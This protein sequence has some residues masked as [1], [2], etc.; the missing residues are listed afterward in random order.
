MITIKHFN[1][2]KLFMKK[3]N[4]HNNMVIVAPGSTGYMINQVEYH[5][6]PDKVEVLYGT[7]ILSKAFRTA[8]NFGVQDVFVVNAQATSDYISIIDT[9]RQYDFS[10]IIPIGINLSDTFYN[11][12]IKRQMYFAELYI[13]QVSRFN[14]S[15]V[16]MTDNHASLYE[17]VDH[18]LGDMSIKAR[19]FKNIAYQSLINFG[20]NLYFVGNNLKNYDMANVVLGSL[21]CTTPIGDYPDF[22]LGPALFDIDDFDMGNTELIYFKNNLLKYTSVENLKNFRLNYDAAKIIGIDRV[23]RFIEKE[24]DFSEFKGKNYSEYVKL[25]VNNKL[26]SFLLGLRGTMIRNHK[27]KSIDFIKTNAGSGMI[28]TNFQISPVTSVEQFDIVMEV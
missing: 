15:V 28:Q 2:P 9:L 21:L 18:F 7:S 8:K 16:I 17:D 12:N 19:Q 3:V 13:D 14:R 1:T 27:V 5:S 6:N 20:R 11:P 23:I 22:N 24:L 10:Y 4:R 26:E 25:Q